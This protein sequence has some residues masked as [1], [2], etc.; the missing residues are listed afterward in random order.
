MSDETLVVETMSGSV[1]EIDGANKR[2]RKTGVTETEMLQPGDWKSYEQIAVV[3]Q[4]LVIVWDEP[5]KE[6]GNRAT[7]SSPLKRIPSFDN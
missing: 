1:Y 5:G 4:C 3:D 2:V 6:F 7:M